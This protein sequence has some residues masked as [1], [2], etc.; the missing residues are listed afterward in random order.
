M[1]PQ[2]ASHDAHFCPEELESLESG[3]LHTGFTSLFIDAPGTESSMHQSSEGPRQ[4]QKS[5]A[6]L[7]DLGTA[8]GL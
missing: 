3:P 4:D 5:V 6:R 8:S 2:T 1:L 7:V